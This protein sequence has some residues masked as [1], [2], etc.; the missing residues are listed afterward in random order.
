M[1]NYKQIDVST[2]CDMASSQSN[3]KEIPSLSPTSTF[4]S[5][6]NELIL[7]LIGKIAPAPFDWWSG[8][9]TASMAIWGA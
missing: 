1:S 7:E 3:P 2:H 9:S 4:H 5:S 6:C 8:L